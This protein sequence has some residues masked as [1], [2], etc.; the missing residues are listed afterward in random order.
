MGPYSCPPAMTTA[1]AKN[2]PSLSAVQENTNQ[3]RFVGERMAQTPEYGV[4]VVMC[5]RLIQVR[6][7]RASQPGTAVGL[8]AKDNQASKEVAS[9]TRGKRRQKSLIPKEAHI[10][11][12]VNWYKSTALA[13][14]SRRATRA[15]R[16]SSMRRAIVD[17]LGGAVPAQTAGMK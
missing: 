13:N 17:A 9:F 6:P 4:E 7:Q 11:Q 16:A 3:E 5:S 1:E 8:L 12:K 2:G 15:A 10:A 14:A